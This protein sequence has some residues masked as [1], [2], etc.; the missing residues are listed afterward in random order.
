M[1]EPVIHRRLRSGDPEAIAE[2]QRRVYSREYGLGDGFTAEV[3]D[4]IHDAVERGWPLSAGAVWLVEHEGALSGSLALTDEGSGVGRVRW[5]VF[6]RELR[7]RGLGRALLAEL[8]AAAR[9]AG[10]REL[11]LDTFSA[12]T[13][14]ASL[15]RR[16][17]F[18]L[19][20]QRET[21]AWG[22]PI[23]LQHY[24]MKL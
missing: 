3:T 1:S 10:L 24:T 16:A 18:E 6:D 4:S 21:D 23:V 12:L 11:E 5:F 13:A 14:A 8:L 22:P 17:G 20:W 15:Y 2:L 19:R 9:A 7:G